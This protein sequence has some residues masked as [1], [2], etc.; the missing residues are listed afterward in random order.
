MLT[1][2]YKHIN[3]VTHDKTIDIID[4]TV[5]HNMH[6]HITPHTNTHNDT[7]MFMICHGVSHVCTRGTHINT[8]THNAARAQ[9]NGTHV[10]TNCVTWHMPHC[11][12]TYVSPKWY[13][14]THNTH[15]DICTRPHNGHNICQ[16]WLNQPNYNDTTTHSVACI[17]TTMYIPSHRLHVQHNMCALCGQ[18]T[19]INASQ[20]TI[21]LSHW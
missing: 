20:H 19:D 16:S 13:A 1:Y 2:I 4:T 3:Y 11:D 18:Y 17:S 9:H 12:G 14:T 10:S 8:H 5:H 6:A 7:H 21:T 15:M